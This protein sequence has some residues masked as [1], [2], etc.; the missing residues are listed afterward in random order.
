MMAHGYGTRTAAFDLK[1]GPASA[2]GARRT[3][4]QLRPMGPFLIECWKRR[5][6]EFQA[7]QTAD[8]T[9]L[10]LLGPYRR[11]REAIYEARSV[12]DFKPVCATLLA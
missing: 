11:F 8:T 10:G 3:L 1:V 4:V 7:A 2:F 5:M 9:P 6:G 12:P